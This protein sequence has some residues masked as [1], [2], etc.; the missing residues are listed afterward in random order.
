MQALIIYHLISKRWGGTYSDHLKYD[1]PQDKGDK[2]NPFTFQKYLA[3][4]TGKMENMPEINYSTQ[5]PV[6]AIPL[7]YT[8]C[9][10][11]IIN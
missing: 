2:S 10:Y 6:T 8:L 1:L 11:L 4:M 9:I 7:Q 5:Y 3:N